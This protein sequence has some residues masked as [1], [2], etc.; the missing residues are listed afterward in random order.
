MAGRLDPNHDATAPARIEIIAIP[1]DDAIGAPV[2]EPV[3]GAAN[4]LTDGPPLRPL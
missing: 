1:L 4:Y 2:R 3:T